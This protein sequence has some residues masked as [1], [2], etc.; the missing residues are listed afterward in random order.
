MS[1][2]KH[3]YIRCHSHVSYAYAKS[4]NSELSGME[5]FTVLYKHPKLSVV[6]GG[7]GVSYSV[8]TS[9]T[10]VYKMYILLG[11]ITGPIL[12]YLYLYLALMF[13]PLR[14]TLRKVA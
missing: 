7:G 14:L 5:S 9:I 12:Q 3:S 2:I 11:L 8:V 4:C 6:A 13:G 10:I 1:F